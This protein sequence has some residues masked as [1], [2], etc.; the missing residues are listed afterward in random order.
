[1]LYR[2]F[3]MPNNNESALRIAYSIMYYLPEFVD[4]EYKELDNSYT[5]KVK[6]TAHCKVIE[7]KP[8]IKDIQR[9]IIAVKVKL[10]VMT[11]LMAGIHVV[12]EDTEAAISKVLRRIGMSGTKTD[13]FRPPQA[14]TGAYIT[15]TFG[16]RDNALYPLYIDTVSSEK[17]KNQELTK[18]RRNKL[19]NM[20]NDCYVCP[21]G[22]DQCYLACRAKTK[23]GF[24]NEKV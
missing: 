12:W 1:M 20:Q 16:C 22:K 24:K 7:A 3:P 19:C 6:F 11:S 10:L 18:L 17:K 14:L 15:V 13:G 4:E 9:G 23:K 2:L 21:K 8:Y 5:G